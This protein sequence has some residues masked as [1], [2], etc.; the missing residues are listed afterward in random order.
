MDG[1]IFSWFYLKR[2][3]INFVILEKD[4]NIL[5]TSIIKI[6]LIIILSGLAYNCG[7]K[8]SY[9]KVEHKLIYEEYS[10]SQYLADIYLPNFTTDNGENVLLEYADKLSDRDFGGLHISFW[11]KEFSK[12][13]MKAY[14]DNDSFKPPAGTKTFLANYGYKKKFKEIQEIYEF[15]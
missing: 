5:K 7:K 4:L 8:Y 9:K 10:G 13:E 3:L 14:N 15:K 12:D 1:R 6:I 2:V 11:N